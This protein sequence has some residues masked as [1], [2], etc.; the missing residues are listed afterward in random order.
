MLKR[1]THSLITAVALLFM[2][3]V[4]SAL[5]SHGPR[6][7]TTHAVHRSTR[8]FHHPKTRRRTHR[9][10]GA[11]VESAKSRR[12]PHRSPM[13]PV[14][15]VAP[16]SPVQ[17]TLPIFSTP[18]TEPVVPVTPTSPAPTPTSPA[19]TPT[20]TVT[21]V[22][23]ISG[24]TT[25]GDT[26][27]ATAGV[28]SGEPTSY[29]YQWQDCTALGAS[30]S[31]IA[32]ATASTYAL[33]ASDVGDT[34]RV[35]VS[36]SNA[37]GSTSA[38]SA[39]TATI[40]A[41]PPPP[42]PTASFTY[43]PASP[44]IGQ[45]VS[46]DSASSTCPDGPCTYEWSDDGGTT[47][48]V[49]ALWPLGS[50][51]IL[52][53]TFSGAGTK[54]V[55][56][57]VTDA[58][59][60]TAT[61]EHDVAVVEAPPPPPTAPAN[62]VPPSIGGS[63][64]E[65]ETLSASAGTWTGG[66]T[67]YAYQW[68]DCNAAGESCVSIA[69]ATSS[70]R[71]LVAGDVGHTLRVVVTASNAGGSAKA[72][73]AATATVVADPPPPPPPP[74]PTNIAPPVVSGSTVEGQTL[75]ASSGAWAESPTSYTYQWQDCNS[76]GAGCAAIAGATSG[77]HVLASSDV[78]RTLRV[79]VKAANAGGT[80]EASSTATG[81]V[82]A[83]EKP[84]GSTPKHC[85]DNPEFEGTARIEACGYPALH[86]VGVE[87]GGKKCSE[88]TPSAGISSKAE[89]EKIE[90]KNITGHVTISNNHV[91]LNN[92]CVAASGRTGAVTVECINGH[93]AENI[94]IEN[95]D[96]RGESNIEE[97]TKEPDNVAIEANCAWE[98][99]RQL[100]EVRKTAMWNCSSCTLGNLEVDESYVL[101]N[102]GQKNANREGWH[103]E[104]AYVNGTGAGVDQGSVIFSD[105]TLLNPGAETAIIFGDT[106]TGAG[107]EECHDKVRL[108][109]SL[110]AGSGSMFQICGGG[111]ATGRGTGEII[112]ENDRFARCTKGIEG[113]PAR[114]KPP[115]AWA[116]LEPEAYVYG[117]EFGY[118]PDGAANDELLGC[119]PECPTGAAFA[120]EGNYWDDNLEKV[121]E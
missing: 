22:P 116:S 20:P 71:Q 95:S 75:T 49:P 91:T 113:S 64:T 63:A 109:N 118:F 119:S 70:S 13:K 84:K 8:R 87:V 66:P 24:T 81:L 4:P 112:I 120:W 37:G 46:F 96:V 115:S 50:G 43:S 3:T 33:R 1:F 10:H 19:P 9:R 52:Q 18:P 27:S 7:A 57:V 101:A 73:S 78:G 25:E 111:R 114:C 97:G 48:P 17:P 79:V 2:L 86:N 93:N 55:R 104:D 74:A 16:V 53:Y 99:T 76:S 62:T 23:S 100:P 77:T 88:L 106:H 83:E 117:E 42:S 58:T 110:L 45:L 72:S 28:W 80:G 105:D 38:P 56:L 11:A 85:F 121:A 26:L 92:D 60:Q 35:V 47:R 54:Y 59:G 44:I 5:A 65:G 61:V 30:C 14:S 67:S 69:G 36:A 102:A 31:D 51:Q 94:K 103:N 90:N 40:A 21:T 6:S 107:G 29:S 108:T 98:N 89:G 12:A 68:Q 32:D 82:T 15:P 34:V 39:V 41:D